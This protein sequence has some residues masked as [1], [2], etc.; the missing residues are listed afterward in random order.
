MS[1]TPEPIAMTAGQSVVSTL[2]QAIKDTAGGGIGGIGC[3]LAGQPFDTVKVKMQAF[4]DVHKGVVSCLRRVVAREGLLGLYAGS[5]PAFAVNIGENAV[6]FMCYGQCQNVVRSMFG[7]PAGSELRPHQSACAGSLAAVFSTL[8]VCPLELI[9]CR[10]QAQQEM[11]ERRGCTGVKLW[12]SRSWKESEQFQ[13]GWVGPTSTSR[14]TTSCDMR[15]SQTIK[16]I[17]M[18]KKHGHMQLHIV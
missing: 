5:A 2:V 14:S 16:C 18:I 4:P 11:L 12:V 13:A 6:L 7:L 3:V 9:K 10:R 17:N 15:N 8:V 1:A